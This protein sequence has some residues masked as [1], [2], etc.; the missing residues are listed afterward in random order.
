MPS[1]PGPPPLREVLAVLEDLYPARWAQSWDAVGLV[2]G[3]PEQPVRRV[4]L[5]VDPVAAVVD[6]AL[7]FGADLLLV[8]HPLLLRPVTSVAATSAK[9]RVVHR[10]IGAG[11][12][13]H[14]AHTNADA[15]S[16]GVSDALATALGLRDLV[17]L[18]PLA[19]EAQDTL[20]TFVPT[21]DAERVL[22]ALAAAGAGRA[23]RYE[24]VAFAAPGTG[25]FTPLPGARPAIGRVGE[26]EDVAEVR[27]ELTVPRALRVPVLAALRAAHPYEVPVASFT[28][29]AGP[30]PVLGIGR[31]GE[32]AAP[33][34][35]A[36]F[37]E[38]VAAALPAT[39]QGVRV[40]GD[41][42]APVRRV[43]VCGGSGDSL[44]AEVRAS[45]ADAYV[46]ADLRHHPASEA[47]E[48]GSGAREHSGGRGPA[49]VDVAHWAS[50]W[51]WLP[52]AAA[53]LRAGLAG[54]GSTVDLR[55]S[56][57]RTD[58]WTSRIPSRGE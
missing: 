33:E 11:C 46:T 4:L 27:L 40:A 45:G 31:V 14:V 26:R 13:L 21:A 2:C 38:R 57:T 20:V 42:G 49:L 16:P 55:I 19:G 29:Q 25:T 30:D 58:P 8:H 17:P 24:R 44:F 56:T 53:R 3:D 18:Q 10:L 32:L 7:A 5:A 47:R 50:E 48:H 36:A 6:E 52:E 37:A 51:P 43:A 28:E 23:G 34:P 54:R 15:A 9:G 22:D 1:D 39:E 41:P 35:L 12:A